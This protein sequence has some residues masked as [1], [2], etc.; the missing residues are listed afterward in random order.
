V[1]AAAEAINVPPRDVRPALLAAFARAR[2]L[3]IAIATVETALGA[4]K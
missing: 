2:R 4:A 3:G 1:C